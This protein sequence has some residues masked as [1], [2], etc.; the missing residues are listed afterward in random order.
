MSQE[1]VDSFKRGLDAYN[2]R[3]L[4]AGHVRAA[5]ADAAAS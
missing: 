5:A 1:N 2:R 4:D 3:H